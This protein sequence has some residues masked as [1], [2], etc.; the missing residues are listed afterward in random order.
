MVDVVEVGEDEGFGHVESAGDDVFGIFIGQPEVQS[1]G[2]RRG[3][4]VGLMRSNSRGVVCECGV[5]AAGRI[6]QDM[7]HA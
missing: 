3:V 5:S 6:S 4:R 1:R 7:E 2:W